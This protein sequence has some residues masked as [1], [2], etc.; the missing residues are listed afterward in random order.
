[1][2]CFLIK[3]IPPPLQFRWT[4]GS[5]GCKVQQLLALKFLYIFEK[6]YSQIRLLKEKIVLRLIIDL[7]S[8]LNFLRFTICKFFLQT[9][10]LLKKSLHIFFPFSHWLNSAICLQKPFL[11]LHDQN[12][13][14]KCLGG[15]LCYQITWGKY[16]RLE[17][18]TQRPAKARLKS[19]TIFNIRCLWFTT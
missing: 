19:I 17:K 11:M 12:Y 15:L 6:I 2:F 7:R 3:G 10:N 8:A 18:A 16:Q 1:M 14:F 9:K 5:N 4:W 13:V